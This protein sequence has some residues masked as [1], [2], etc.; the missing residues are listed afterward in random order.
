MRTK[1][2]EKERNH[3]PWE[4]EGEI[5]EEEEEEEGQSLEVPCVP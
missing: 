5:K 1:G 3:L 4:G 2:R